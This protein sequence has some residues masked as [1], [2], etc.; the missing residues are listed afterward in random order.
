MNIPPEI[1]QRWLLSFR[2]ERYIT[3]LSKTDGYLFIMKIIKHISGNSY[4]QVGTYLYENIQ[5]NNHWKLL[6]NQNK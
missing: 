2:D 5:L 4:W 3:E 6:P 1:G